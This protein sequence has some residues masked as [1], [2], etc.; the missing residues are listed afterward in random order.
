MESND[1]AAEEDGVKIGKEKK[2]KKVDDSNKVENNTIPTE[3]TGFRRYILYSHENRAFT[4]EDKE[5]IVEKNE[6]DAKS[7]ENNEESEHQLLSY[8]E[9]AAK[10]F[11]NCIMLLK[12]KYKSEHVS[13]VET[14]YEIKVERNEVKS[15]LEESKEA[16]VNKF[17]EKFEKFI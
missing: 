12:N 2:N 9:N 13:F 6:K 1:S 3:Q 10:Y 4:Y 16:E 14:K 17:S 8:V 5:N 11:R 15:G 7:G